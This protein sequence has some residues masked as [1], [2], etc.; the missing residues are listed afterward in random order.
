MFREC[1][2]HQIFSPDNLA[3]ELLLDLAD[4]M[5]ADTRLIYLC[6]Y[7][8]ERQSLNARTPRNHG[9]VPVVS[10]RRAV[11]RGRLGSAHVVIHQDGHV[12]TSR[13]FDQFLTH[14]AAVAGV[15]HRA[16]IAIE[17]KREALEIRLNVR[18]LP[19]RDFPTVALNHV[20]G[21]YFLRL[22]RGAPAGRLPAALLE[23]E[24]A[25]LVF[26]ARA[27]IGSVDALLAEKQLGHP[28]NRRRP[29]DLEVGNSIRSHIP[30][31]ED[32]PRI[33]HAVVV[34]QVTDERVAHVN[35][36][37]PALDEAVVS[38]GAVIHHNEVVAD[39]DEITRTLSLERRRGSS[40]SE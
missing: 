15:T 27:D 31:L 21:M 20:A 24:N 39:F 4:N 3:V 13:K 9:V 40:G 19:H 10:A 25:A 34:V 32:E 22:R 12:A 26:D 37:M 14:T 29:V 33:V 16:F 38:A 30:A 1:E 11:T 6:E 36:P 2:L 28:R 8:G 5:V 23:H 35:G 18:R 17:A 7:V